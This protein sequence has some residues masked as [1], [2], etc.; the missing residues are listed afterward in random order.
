MAPT[1]IRTSR[2]V[3]VSMVV[4]IFFTTQVAF[5]GLAAGRGADIGPQIVQE[6]LFWGVWAFLTPIVVAA[7]H[8]WPL[9]NKPLY[10]SIVAHVAVS[11]ALAPLQVSIAFGLRPL[12]VWASGYMSSADALQSM[13][14]IGPTFVWGLFMGAFFYWVIVG[15]YTA[16][17]FRGLYVAEQV[18]AA[19]LTSRSAKLEAELAHAK[20][21]A[22]RS[23][24]RPHFLFNTLNAISVLS[25]DDADRTRRM[26]LRL[27]SLLRRSLD[28]EQ[29]EVSLSQELSFLDEYLE[30]QRMRF[31]DRLTVTVAI[32]PTVLNARVP[33]FLLQPVLE[34]AMDHGMAD[35][36]TTVIAVSAD[37]VDGTLHLMV[38]DRG[39]GPGNGTPVHEGIGLGNTRARLHHLYGDRATLNL[40]AAAATPSGRGARVDILLPYVPTTT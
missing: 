13:R 17:R 20:L 19:E 10:R 31:G 32:D 9:D 39:P 5:M 12:L 8:R 21:D 7:V 36:G 28:E 11:A 33:V 18:S 27:S 30:I 4:G 35:D 26:L 6:L 16:L 3:A 14:H 22:L 40:R 1:P 23:Q 2:I 34:N 29:H 37:R 15:V 38:E 24:L 25:R